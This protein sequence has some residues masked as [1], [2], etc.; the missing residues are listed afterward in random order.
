MV[1][2][3]SRILQP[4]GKGDARPVAPSPEL[5]AE[6][7]TQSAMAIAALERELDL[8]RITDRS[9]RT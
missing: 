4:A 2:F 9:T 3:L 5:V 8:L 1:M 6:V 7:K